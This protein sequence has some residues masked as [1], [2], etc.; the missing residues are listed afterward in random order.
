VA[1]QVLAALVQKGKPASEV[2]NLFTPLPQI[3]KNIK[4]DRS[5]LDRPEAEKLFETARQTLG[6]EG[7]LVV[8]ASGTEALIRIMAEG[9]DRGET[10]QVVDK[11]IT[12]LQTLA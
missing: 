11:I 4:L 9:T 10:E 8:R 3:L 5:F 6:E 1:L 7:R 12:G 2:L